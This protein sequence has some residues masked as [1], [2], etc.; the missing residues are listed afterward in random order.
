MIDP[1]ELRIGNWVISPHDDTIQVVGIN[2][3]ETLDILIDKGGMAS[4]RTNPIPIT[5]KWLKRLGFKL[6][7]DYEINYL[8]S[9]KDE[10]GSRLNFRLLDKGLKIQFNMFHAVE[11]QHVHQL[12]NLYFALT[13]EEL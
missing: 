4:H 13:G 3:E 7:T 5:K 2:P 1:K 9:P 12:Q 6:K 11:I 8:L 10:N